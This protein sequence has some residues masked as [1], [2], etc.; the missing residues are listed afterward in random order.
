[1]GMT[2]GRPKTF[3]GA[4]I[5]RA[6]P[7]LPLRGTNGADAFNLCGSSNMVGLPLLDAAATPGV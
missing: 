1:M 6:V 2:P 5:E 4:Q 3:N 7:L